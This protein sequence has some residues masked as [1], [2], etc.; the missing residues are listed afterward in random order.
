M[1]YEVR[2]SDD[3]LQKCPED[4]QRQLFCADEEVALRPSAAGSGIPGVIAFLNG[5]EVRTDCG[6]GEWAASRFSGVFRRF[7]RVSG[8]FRRFSIRLRDLRA[9][10]PSVSY[11]GSWLPAPA[12]QR[13]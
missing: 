13:S 3:R 10:V 8:V 4:C 5:V 11:S 7:Y 6:S 2:H 12:T 1:C 9:S